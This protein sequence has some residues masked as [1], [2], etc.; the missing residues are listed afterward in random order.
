[1]FLNAGFNFLLKETPVWGCGHKREELVTSQRAD[2][3]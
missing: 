3:D 2:F 1:M